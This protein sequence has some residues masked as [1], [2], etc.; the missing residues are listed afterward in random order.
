[1]GDLL[2]RA[3]IWLA[4]GLYAW[5]QWSRRSSGQVPRRGLALSGSGWLLFVAH[6]LL[7]YDVHYE[8][9]Q[10]VAWAETA[11]QTAALTGLDWGGGLYVNY[12]FGLVWLGELAWWARDPRGYGTRAR[13]TELAVRAWFLF[14]IVNGAVVFV[15]GPQRWLG[16]GILAALLWAWRPRRSGP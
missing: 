1:M 13:W 7:A 4:L 6:V 10:A 11:A 5:A 15:A 9:S 14:M 2:T 8:W 12:L 3:T 16:V